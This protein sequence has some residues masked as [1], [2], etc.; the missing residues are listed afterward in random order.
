MHRA[1]VISLLC[2]LFPALCNTSYA[3]STLQQKINTVID[4]SRGKIGVGILSLNTADSLVI[5]NDV[6]YPMQSTYK[7]PLAM[8]IL[9]LVDDGKL[10]LTQMI[11]I[12]RKELDQKTWSPI[13]DDF[14]DQ[15]VDMTLSQLLIYTISKSDNN[16]CDKL[17]KIAGGCTAV[18]DYIHSLG[19]TDISIVATE[20][21]MHKSWKV[22]YSNWCRPSAMLQL[23]RMLYDGKSLSA[24]SKAFL[25]KAMVASTNSDARLKGMLPP[26]IIVAHKTGTSGTN[27]KGIKAATNDVG[28]VMLPNAPYAIV[29]FDSD[30]PGGVE[31]GEHI[32]AEI[33]RIAY[34]EY[35]RR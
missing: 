12:T 22:Q 35:A 5:N 24:S 4:T 9:H 27:K 18:N 34:E 20:A 25:M 29:V 13:V 3:Q 19:V 28:I 21:Q 32:I 1:I 2:L 17:F 31:R 14:P 15:D 11:H 26:G 7:F 6:R 23:L 33:S 30:Y 10:S 16:G 8:M